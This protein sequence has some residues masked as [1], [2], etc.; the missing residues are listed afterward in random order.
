MSGSLE[1]IAKGGILWHFCPARTL[2]SL[3][4]LSDL[5][6]GTCAV[7]PIMVDAQKIQK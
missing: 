1:G 2:Q 3:V 6:A 7:G 5:G 4:N